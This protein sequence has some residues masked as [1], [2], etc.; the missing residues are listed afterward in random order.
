MRDP[1]CLF[2][3]YGDWSF[4]FP[5]NTRET[6]TMIRID[7]NLNNSLKCIKITPNFKGK[8]TVLKHMI[9]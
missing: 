9:T 5:F 3:L 8:N 7:Q 4:V 1:R 6:A 2:C